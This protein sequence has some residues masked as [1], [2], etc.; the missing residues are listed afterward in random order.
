MT[1]AIQ[2]VFGQALRAKLL[3]A[4]TFASLFKT[5]INLNYDLTFY[6]GFLLFNNSDKAHE[7]HFKDGFLKPH[8]DEFLKPIDRKLYQWKNKH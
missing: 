8:K 3:K 5:V 2:E 6:W 1:Q 7:N 4:A